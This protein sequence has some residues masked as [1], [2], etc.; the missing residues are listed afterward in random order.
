MVATKKPTA[1]VKPQ[2]KAKPAKTAPKAKAKPTAAKPTL[3]LAVAEKQLMARYKNRK[4]VK[5]SLRDSGDP[6]TINS[7]GHKRTI[8]IHCEV[9]GCKNIRRIATSDLHQVN[10]CLD[11]AKTRN[12]PSTTKATPKKTTT[13]TVKSKPK[14]KPKHEEAVANTQPAVEQT[15]TSI[16]MEST[17]PTVTAS[18]AH[19]SVDDMNS[20]APEADELMDQFVEQQLKS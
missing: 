19:G 6:K 1:K 3:D 15:P 4:I 16:I 10:K 14:P 17:A 20:A 11:C 2:Q 9:K 18:E 8:E 12:K 7:F 13:T 5:D